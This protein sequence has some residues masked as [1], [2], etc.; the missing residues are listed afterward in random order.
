MSLRNSDSVRSVAIA[1]LLLALTACA[2]TPPPNEQ[3]AV[4][5]ASVQ[6]AEQ[7]GA[8]ELSPVELA[9]ARDKLVR[10]DKAVGAD[11]AALATQLAVQADAEAQLA[12]ARAIQEKSHK[13]ALEFDASM[14]ALRQESNRPSQTAQ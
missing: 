9:G 14:T 13:A 3:L 5:K 12:E 8:P 4:A 10:A 6:R 11:N 1:A 7:A 2:T